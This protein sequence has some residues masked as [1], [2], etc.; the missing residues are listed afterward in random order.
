MA[1]KEKT[2]KYKA[3]D[4]MEWTT[5]N[6]DYQG[7]VILLERYDRRPSDRVA[8]WV[9]SYPKKEGRIR[10]GVAEDELTPVA[11]T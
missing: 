3:G 9:E 5:F 7:Q 1:K 8:W 11:R 6:G 2:P 10:V 4:I